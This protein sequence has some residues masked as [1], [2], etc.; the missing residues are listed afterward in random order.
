MNT[1]PDTDLDDYIRQQGLMEW[2]ADVNNFQPKRKVQKADPDAWQVLNPGGIF[3]G[4]L[5]N[6]IK[7]VATPVAENPHYHTEKLDHYA[8]LFWNRHG[9][10]VTAFLSGLGSPPRCE[11]ALYYLVIQLVGGG[12]RWRMFNPER[13]GHAIGPVIDDLWRGLEHLLP[14]LTSVL[15]QIL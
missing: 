1:D 11:E 6:E 13:H 5:D 2:R 15:E 8:Y 10:V 9:V 7:Y 4:V 3:A 12:G 14:N